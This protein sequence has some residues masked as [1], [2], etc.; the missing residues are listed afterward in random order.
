MN[1]KSVCCISTCLMFAAYF[2]G[3][4]VVRWRLIGIERLFFQGDNFFVGKKIAKSGLKWKPTILR[5]HAFF[6][7]AKHGPFSPQKA[8]DVGIFDLI[9]KERRAK[10]QSLGT[11]SK[12]EAQDT[13]VQ[14]LLQ[15]CPQFSAH[16]EANDAISCQNDVS[17]EPQECDDL[18]LTAVHGL[19]SHSP[20]VNPAEKLNHNLSPSQESQ[21]RNALNAQT[22]DQF[23]AYAAQY[24]PDNES[25]QVELIAQ[26]Q[27]RH[28]RQYMIYIS[29]NP[30]A[31]PGGI[32]PQNS[33][34]ALHPSQAPSKNESVSDQYSARPCVKNQS[35]E[36]ALCKSTKDRIVPCSVNEQQ[37]NGDLV[38]HIP[39]GRNY[40]AAPQMW[41]R[42]DIN[43]F[44]A[45]LAK[46]P[47]SVL[48]VGSGE[49][50]T[51][52]VSIVPSGNCLVWEFATDDFDIGP[53][54][55]LEWDTTQCTMES[56]PGLLPAPEKAI[57]P[58][59]LLSR[60]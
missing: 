10:W 12:A 48:N 28:F 55:D 5:S 13:F 37:I 16:L 53:A 46:D 57:V 23:R 25:K 18:P 52:R 21:I 14:S 58:Q 51:I 3:L 43:E 29:E 50:V 9:G 17:V 36:A 33:E 39:D 30:P 54:D 26:L 56:H 27:D 45:L 60:S 38:A 47:E 19:N 41:T 2:V 22:L 35:F 15:I 11:M 40:V 44:K 7:K 31:L 24:Y 20:S 4:V 34:E 6:T 49:L 1:F 32:S 8:P 59:G 42:N